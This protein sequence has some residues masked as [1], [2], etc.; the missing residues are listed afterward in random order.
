MPPPVVNLLSELFWNMEFCD[1]V[2]VTPAIELAKLALVTSQDE[3]EDETDKA[4]TDS[5]NDTDATLVDD[6]A[7]RSAFDRSSPPAPV[8]SPKS[9][10]GSVLGKRARDGDGD[11]DADGE[12][13]M[14]I[15][16][17]PAHSPP[18][19]SVASPPSTK[20]SG[21]SESRRA[22]ED[23]MSFI[24]D[25]IGS[26]SK[27]PATGNGDGDADPDVE[28][29]DGSSQLQA[30]GK[31]PPPL[32]P[33]KRQAADSVMMFGMR[34]HVH[35]NETWTEHAVAGRQHDVSECMDNCMFQIETALLDFQDE[36]M[37]G[38]AQSDKT[39]VIKRSVFQPCRWSRCSVRHVSQVVLRQEAAT[40][41]FSVAK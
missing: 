15:D 1:T 30:A 31:V 2:A 28:M 5:S 32:P 33:R 21:S 25:A 36:G 3:E 4:G 16:S 34:C 13:P 10:T 41:C 19:P 14:D 29:K 38:A 40:A 11:A 39:S 7:P 12:L 18:G 23:P 24:E 8:Q 9:P 37:A 22:S 35:S 17:T 27:R 20:A 26:S 6:M